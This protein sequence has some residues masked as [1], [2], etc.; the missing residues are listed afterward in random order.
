MLGL[1]AEQIGTVLVGASLAISAIMGGRKG[2]DILQK[3]PA[4][5]GDNVME[6]AGA[7][8]SDKGVEKM[9]KALDE[10]TSA[11]ILMTAAIERDVSAK[12][13][14]TTA[15]GESSLALNRN[16]EVS[17]EMRDEI[18]ETGSRLEGLTRELIRSGVRRHD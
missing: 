9:V 14:L 11:A 1:T 12:A 16:S 5:A 18:K 6:V 7:I 8:V 2:R 10:F 4:E 15:L 17:E 13:R 3:K